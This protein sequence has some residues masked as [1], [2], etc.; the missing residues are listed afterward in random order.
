MKAA[1]LKT[2]VYMFPCRGK[3]ATAQAHELID[4]IPS[5]LYSRVWLDIESNPSPGCSWGDHNGTSNCDFTMELIKAV[6]GK[7]KSV[8]IYASKYMWTTIFSSQTACSQA[9]V[10][11]PLW[12]AHYDNNP[13][14]SDFT[15]F[16]GWKQPNIKQ[17][18]GTESFCGAS[19][20]RSWRP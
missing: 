16:A 13:S 1:G 10:D 15:A 18:H 2:D 17:Y 12:Y 5:D 14:F 3:N 19:V 9:S 20:D 11:V 7:G 6:K 4:S 8:G